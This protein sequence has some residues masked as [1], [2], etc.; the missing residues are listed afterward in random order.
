LREEP[1]GDPALIEDLDG[2]GVQAAGARAGEVLAWAPLDDGNVDACQ[3]QLARQHQPRRP[4][5]TDD[6]GMLSHRT[7]A[8][9]QALLPVMTSKA[10]PVGRRMASSPAQA[11]AAA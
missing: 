11:A 6:H 8:G 5:P 4:G 2:A 7:P 9:G 1:I 10:G 3:R